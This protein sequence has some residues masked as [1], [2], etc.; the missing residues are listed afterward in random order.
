MDSLNPQEGSFTEDA[1]P[2]D[3]EF[4]SIALETYK[5]KAYVNILDAD[6]DTVMTLTLN[7]AHE[8]ME[9]VFREMPEGCVDASKCLGCAL[10]AALEG[11]R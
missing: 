3:L 10:E 1:V 2:L 5:G 11:V 7:E 8:V 9:Q 6:G 4:A